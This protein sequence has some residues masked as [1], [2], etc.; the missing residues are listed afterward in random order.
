[1]SE[2]AT[3]GNEIGADAGDEVAPLG[4]VLRAARESRGESLPEVARALKLSVRQLEAIEEER[5]SE[6][7][8]P[9]FVKGFVRNYGRHLG[10]DVG[11]MVTARWG[12]GASMIELV[13]MGNAAGILPVSGERSGMS[14]L[15]VPV[16][17]VLVIGGALA[18]YF[19]GFDPNP[20]A[21]EAVQ[22]SDALSGSA[23]EPEAEGFGPP[24]EQDAVEGEVLPQAP[25]MV[26]PPSADAPA[27]VQLPEQLLLPEPAAKEVASAAQ[28]AEVPETPAG[29][30]AS[31]EVSSGPGRLVFRLE[32]ESWLEVRDS[33]DRRLY[34]GVGSAGSVRVVQGQGP[35]SLVIG[36]AA[37]VRLEHAGR[38][39]ELAPHT[40]P[41]GVARLTVE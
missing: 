17:L 25:A 26:L 28:A 38:N 37:G 27:P 7:P 6:L 24:V 12:A 13:P 10:V 35:F 32:G 9:A 4:A 8:G 1:M 29:G 16:V 23:V 30:E 14:K 21:Q 20:G 11:P 5:F 33:R 3:D 41:G 18:W 15:F 39:I 34:S 19:D 31:A 40:S 36:N 2:Y 22:A